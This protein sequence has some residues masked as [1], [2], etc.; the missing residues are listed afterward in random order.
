MNRLFR[1]APITGECW[2]RI[3]GV[4][5]A[6]LAAV[7]LEKWLRIKRRSKR[8]TRSMEVRQPQA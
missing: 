7:E 8:E 6:A 1:T 4:A 2:L 3:V 5:A